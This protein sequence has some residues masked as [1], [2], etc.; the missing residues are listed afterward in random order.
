MR[1]LF[2]QCTRLFFALGDQRARRW[3]AGRAPK[4]GAMGK[5]NGRG[6]KKKGSVERGEE[7]GEGVGEWLKNGRGKDAEK[8]G[9]WRDGGMEGWLDG[10]M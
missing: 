3:A 5:K 8:M 9:E 4:D 10:W 6:K 1:R 2:R 7:G